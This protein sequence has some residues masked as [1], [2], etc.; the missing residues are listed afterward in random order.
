MISKEELNRMG[1]PAG[2]GI[3][4]KKLTQAEIRE[5]NEDDAALEDLM[6][7]DTSYN[8]RLAPG[9]KARIVQFINTNSPFKSEIIQD[10]N[11]RSTKKITDGEVPW[12]I[13]KRFWS[14]LAHNASMSNLDQRE[15]EIESIELELN[16]MEAMWTIPR[17]QYDMT[18]HNDM[19]NALHLS[20]IR[21]WQNKDGGERYLSAAEIQDDLK[22]FKILKSK[23]PSRMA[24]AVRK[25]RGESNE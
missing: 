24:N 8:Q 23:Q 25:I 22:A 19:R 16:A 18:V 9:D 17:K 1:I 14:W 12:Y 15:L 20:K 10:E 11:G 2:F 21:L 7:N 4:E 3:P 13:Y 5:M 6:S